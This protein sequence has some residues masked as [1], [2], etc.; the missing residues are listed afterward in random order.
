MP[1][2]AGERLHPSGNSRGAPEHPAWKSSVCTIKANIGGEKKIKEQLEVRMGT[3]KQP[4]RLAKT[5]WSVRDVSPCRAKARD[6]TPGEGVTLDFGADGG[7]EWWG[8][9]RLGH[10]SCL[11]HNP[12]LTRA[13]LAPSGFPHSCTLLPEPRL[14]GGLGNEIGG[15][16]QLQLLGNMVSSSEVVEESPI[17]L[18]AEQGSTDRG[19]QGPQGQ[20]VA[21]VEVV[22]RQPC[23]WDARGRGSLVGKNNTSVK[24]QNTSIPP[25]PAP[26]PSLH[27]FLGESSTGLCAARRP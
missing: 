4:L 2:Q 10:H 13:L 17:F 27:A 22:Q 19:P 8:H 24:K 11:H 16:E 5:G 20:A 6:V 3:Q 14:L 21:G 25:N 15:V 23:G 26:A 9:L 1:G 12:A 7:A 18:L